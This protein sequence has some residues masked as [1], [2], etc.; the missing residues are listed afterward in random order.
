[1]GS[2]QSG[3]QGLCNALRRLFV[4]FGVPIELSSDGG[5]EFSAKVTA[6]FLKRWDVRHRM[7]S[8]YHPSSNGRAELAVKSTKRLLMENVGPDGNL[9]NDKMVRALLT[10]RNTPD[11]GCKLSP[12]QILLGRQLKGSLPYGLHQKGHNVVQ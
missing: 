10:Q 4:T 7:S 5:P 9:E 8:A 3:A 1:M 6:D 2:R 12:A 11:P